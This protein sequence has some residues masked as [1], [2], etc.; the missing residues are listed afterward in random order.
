MTFKDVK[1]QK[2]A[3]GEKTHLCSI[4]GKF[5][6]KAYVLKQHIRTHFYQEVKCQIC[7]KIFA[8]PPHLARHMKEK[9]SPVEVHVCSLCGKEYDSIQRFKI[10]QKRVHAKKRIPP[11]NQICGVCGKAFEY[12]SFLKRHLE[13]HK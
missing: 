2:S 4:C 9:H 3:N 10:H 6:N 8:G 5:F 13:T 7:E 11:K 12:P 1:Q